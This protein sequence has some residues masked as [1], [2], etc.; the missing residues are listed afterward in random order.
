MKKSREK[1]G[2]L[3]F[4]SY[5]YITKLLKTMTNDQKIEKQQSIDSLKN[6]LE[7]LYTAQQERLSSYAKK[8]VD[9]I[10]TRLKPSFPI[11][12]VI[13]TDS[14]KLFTITESLE[15]GL[16]PPYPDFGSEVTL[17]NKFNAFRR[18]EIK[19]DDLIPELTC[20]GIRMNFGEDVKVYTIDKE[21]TKIQ[22]MNFLATELQNYSTANVGSSFVK[23]IV[24]M[25]YEIRKAEKEINELHYQAS[26]LTDEIKKASQTEELENFTNN[27]KEDNWYKLKSNPLHVQATKWSRGDYESYFHIKK[28]SAKTVT[29]DIYRVD[30]NRYQDTKRVPIADAHK[31]LMKKELLTESPLKKENA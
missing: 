26:V 8:L 27:F 31:M 22:L 5:I 25:F 11:G 1:F 18:T 15:K 16:N 28:I 30:S 24:D 21:I 4:F 7:P 9:T 23:Q 14:I 19:R 10:T 20:S 2:F 29:I 12:A 6:Q 3:D 17:N 13:Y